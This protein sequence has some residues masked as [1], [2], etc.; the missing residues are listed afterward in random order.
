MS[1]QSDQE[2]RLEEAFG[3]LESQEDAREVAGG[4]DGSGG[5]R[6]AVGV[7]ATIVALIATGMAGYAAFVAWEL[8]QSQ[9]G[10]DERLAGVDARLGQLGARPEL[11]GEL[12]RVERSLKAELTSTQSRM[13]NEL[14]KALQSIESRMGTSSQ[15]WLL[16]EAEFLVRMAHHKLQMQSDAAGAIAL[17]TAAD[18][19]IRDAELASGFAIRQAIA[20]DVAALELAPTV[21]V[22]GYFLRLSALEGQIGRLRETN[23]TFESTQPASEPDAAAD[24]GGGLTDALLGYASRAGEYIGDQFEF[25]RG[26]APIQPLMPQVERYYLEQNLRLKLQTARLALLRQEQQVYGATLE[27]A[28]EWVTGYFDRDD[29]VTV[30]LSGALL[31]LRG[32]RITADVPRIGRSLEAIRGAMVN[33]EDTPSRDL[34]SRPPPQAARGRAGPRPD[35]V[36]TPAVKQ[37]AVEQLTP[38][39]ARPDAETAVTI[40]PVIGGGDL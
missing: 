27:S 14:G 37:A 35:A 38:A 4:R 8:K 39:G 19:V 24:A 13:T 11:S 6:S 2:E 29:P 20:E 31:E 25:R 36:E 23:P 40:E 17:L 5:S 12:D 30:S 22:T 21:D 32:A 1:E 10:L 28:A 9:P 7:I 3:Q 34:S 33:F 16:A 26:H 18:D 15:D